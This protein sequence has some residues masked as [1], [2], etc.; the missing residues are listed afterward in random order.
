MPTPPYLY[1]RHTWPQLRERAAE[2]PQPVVILTIGSVEQHGPHLPLDVDNLLIRRI[3]ELAAEQIPDRVLLLPHLPYGFEEHHLDFPGTV[4]ITNH[5]LENFVYELLRSVTHHGFRRLLIADGHGSNMPILNYAARRVTLDT[6]ALCGAFIWAALIA[7][8]M[9]EER[10]SPFPGGVAHACELETSAYLHLDPGAVDMN[11]AVRDMHEYPSEFHWQDLSAGAPLQ[12]MD[13]FSRISHTG[14]TGDPTTAS[15]EK[16]RRWVGL[17]V[18]RLVKLIVEFQ[19][20]ADRPR[21]DH[22]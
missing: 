21:V 4:S 2:V 10:E 17:A 22:H 14:I 19:G 16:G 12:F 15:A 6:P 1:D 18:D 8:V 11:L 5:T 3:V 9:R 7:D 20:W 13:F